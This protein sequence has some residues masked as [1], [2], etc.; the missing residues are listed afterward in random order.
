MR[1][2]HVDDNFMPTIG[3]QTNFLAKYA[4]RHGHEAIVVAGDSIRYWTESGFFP[5]EAAE[6]LSEYDAEFTRRHGV[7]IIRVHSRGQLLH[8]EV[9]EGRVF[10]IVKDLKPDVVL[11]HYCDALTGVRFAT[12]ARRL[13]YPMLSDCH[14]VEAGAE[15]QALARRLFH[16]FYRTF[17]TPVFRR[18]Q[19]PVIAVGED[20]KAYCLRHYGMTDGMLP[21]MPFA[22][23]TMLFRPHKEA[24]TDFRAKYGIGEGD[25]VCVYTGKIQPSKKVLLLAKAFGRKFNGAG[26]AVLVLV[27]SGAGDYYDAVKAAVDSSENTVLMFPTQQVEGLAWFYQAADLAVWPG[28]CSLSFFDAQACAL[29]VV[30][31]RISSNEER[32]K[33]EFDNGALFAPDDEGALRAALESLCNMDR[34]RLKQMGDNGLKIIRDRYDYDN[35][36]GDVEKLMEDTRTKWKA[37]RC[38][39]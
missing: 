24:R 9:L 3:F 13:P 21:V 17:V 29:P 14:M 10:Q 35:V 12:K 7:P 16:A 36:S 26:R 28:A 27:G 25:F 32:I 19:I 34:G 11:V 39:S 31:E 8:R 38:T 37:R 20:Y 18:N 5:K 4:V 6:H 30:A 33:P 15:Q 2:V 23:D 22:A 1:I